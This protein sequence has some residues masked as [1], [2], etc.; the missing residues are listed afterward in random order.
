MIQRSNRRISNSSSD[1]SDAS[2]SSGKSRKELGMM[3]NGT[4][5]AEQP[6]NGHAL[7]NGVA[8]KKTDRRQ[9]IDWEIPRKLLHSSIGG[10]LLAA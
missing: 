9:K 6:V 2:S 4:Y 10:L 1:L 5:S 8:V 7:G 3:P